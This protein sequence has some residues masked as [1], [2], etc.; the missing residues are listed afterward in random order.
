MAST[1]LK[2]YVYTIVRKYD[3]STLRVSTEVNP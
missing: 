1:T 3:S 2:R